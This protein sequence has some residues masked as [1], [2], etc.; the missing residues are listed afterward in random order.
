FKGLFFPFR[1]LHFVFGEFDRYIFPLIGDR[2]AALHTR[3]DF[4]FPL[5]L[6]LIGLLFG[7]EIGR[8]SQSANENHS[9]AGAHEVS[10]QWCLELYGRSCIDRTTKL[11]RTGN[12]RKQPAQALARSGTT[13]VCRSPPVTWT[14]PLESTNTLVS[15]RTPNSGK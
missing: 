11:S 3:F 12:A 15:L 14:P 6:V 10:S 5:N 7:R 2:F 1:P 4:P 13:L 9:D 8:Q